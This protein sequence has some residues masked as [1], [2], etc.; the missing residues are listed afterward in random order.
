MAQ[1]AAPEQP[2]ASQSLVSTASLAHKRLCTQTPRG[3]ARAGR[4]HKRAHKHNTRTQVRMLT[5]TQYSSSLLAQRAQILNSIATCRHLHQAFTC[6]HLLNPSTASSSPLFLLKSAQLSSADYLQKCANQK[7]ATSAKSAAV[8]A[9]TRRQTT[10]GRADHHRRERI[11]SARQ[12]PRR[13]K[14]IKHPQHIRQ[15]AEPAWQL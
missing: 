1:P 5:Y 4:V 13:S 6:T 12:A 9:R 3:L 2:C 14:P 11:V 8:R 7:E 15:P 10:Q